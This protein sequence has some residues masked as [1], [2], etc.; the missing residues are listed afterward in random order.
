MTKKKY[1]TRTNTYIM[2]D[3]VCNLATMI[4]GTMLLNELRKTDINAY[5]PDS[6]SKGMTLFCYKAF[7]HKM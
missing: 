2:E 5:L 6:G 7:N 3:S 4:N 1:Q